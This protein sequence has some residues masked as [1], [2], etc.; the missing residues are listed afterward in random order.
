MKTFTCLTNK[1]ALAA[2]ATVSNAPG[3]T[4]TPLCAIEERSSKMLELDPALLRQN[5]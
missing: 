3:N 2:Q 1:P 5:P 4:L